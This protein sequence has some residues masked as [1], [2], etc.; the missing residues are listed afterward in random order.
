MGSFLRSGDIWLPDPISLSVDDEIIWSS[1]TGR[2][3]SGIMIG[4]IVAEK[5]NIGIEWAFLQESEVKL[6]K[7]T[8]VA[9][10]VPLTFRDAGEDITIMVYRGTL[11]KE[12]IGRLGDGIF[13]YRKVSTSIVQQ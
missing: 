10:F 7:S 5:K 2:T 13:W 8:I 9:G 1:D 12:A 11:Q 3:M 4:D 6:I